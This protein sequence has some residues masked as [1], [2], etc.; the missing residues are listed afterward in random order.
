MFNPSVFELIYVALAA[1]P[2]KRGSFEID[3]Q[4]T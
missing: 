2:P 4:I 1:G 3:M